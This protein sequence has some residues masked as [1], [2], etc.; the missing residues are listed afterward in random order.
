MA[1]GWYYCVL[2]QPDMVP[3][4]LKKTFSPYSHAYFIENFGNQIKARYYYL[5]KNYIPLLKYIEEMK[6]REAIL[7]GRVE[8]LAMEACIRYLTKDKSS[9]FASL[10]EAYETASPNNIL[11]PFTE[12]G[13]DMRTLSSAALRDPNIG[14]PTPWLETVKRNSSLYAKHQSSFISEYNKNYK[15]DNKTTLS[16]REN[17]ILRDLYRGFS[18]LEI[19]DKQNLSINTVN[20]N[21]NKIYKKLNAHSIADAIRISADQKLVHNETTPTQ[22]FT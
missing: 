21:I 10:R 11:M 12:L 14:I 4:W 20:L 19:A 17:E 2:R 16:P 1:T 13:K 6:R 22:Q 3:D 18:R 5:T 15:I 9:A 7:Y 8:M